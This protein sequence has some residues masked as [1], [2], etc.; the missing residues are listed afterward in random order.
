MKITKS[1]QDLIVA[2]SGQVPLRGKLS[3]IA[4]IGRRF[5]MAWTSTIGAKTSYT[6]NEGIRFILSRR[7]PLGQ[8]YRVV[9]VRIYVHLG[10]YHQGKDY[11][12]LPV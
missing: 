11:R 5:Y 4:Y 3:I 2:L 7:V 10:K 6:T 1:L 12:A 9:P 8:R